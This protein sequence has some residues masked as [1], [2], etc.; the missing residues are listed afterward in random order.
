MSHA[1]NVEPNQDTPSTGW[2]LARLSYSPSDR[3]EWIASNPE[4]FDWPMFY[5][6]RRWP[7]GE[8]LVGL[9]VGLPR[10]PC[11]A[12]RSPRGLSPERPEH[13]SE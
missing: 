9:D 11:P 10:S 4:S 5:G 7:R 1:V 12:R 3:N 13:F 6:F 8:F 2:R